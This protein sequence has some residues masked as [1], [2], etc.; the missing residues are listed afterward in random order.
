MI[1]SFLSKLFGEKKTAKQQPEVPKS[2][3]QTNRS[4]FMNRYAG[5]VYFLI[6]W[7]IFGYFL[8]SSAREK[9]EKDGWFFSFL[10]LNYKS[11]IFSIRSFNF[12]IFRNNNI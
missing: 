7:H 10:L 6:V 4:L 11:K 9:A 8:I 12:F 3:K 5:G 2:F 1:G